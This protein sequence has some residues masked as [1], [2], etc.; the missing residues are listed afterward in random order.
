MGKT[1]ELRIP[2][3]AIDGDAVHLIDGEPARAIIR[4]PIEDAWP[5]KEDIKAMSLVPD[6]IAELKRCYEEL[7]KADE[8]GEALWNVLDNWDICKVDYSM[9]RPIQ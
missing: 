2:H 6:L 7:D 8:E 9:S 5:K 3:P 1:V 4:T